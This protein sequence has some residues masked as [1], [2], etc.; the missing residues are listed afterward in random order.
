MF[1]PEPSSRY[2]LAPSGDA[3]DLDLAEVLLLGG[4]GTGG[5]EQQANESQARQH[6]GDLPAC[7]AQDANTGISCPWRPR[8]GL[9]L[10]FAATRARRRPFAAARG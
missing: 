9:T 2:R 7:E 10:K 1:P 3:L 5:G 6:A 8:N 4:Q